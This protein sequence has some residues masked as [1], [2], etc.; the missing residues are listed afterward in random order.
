MLPYSVNSSRIYKSKSAKARQSNSLWI[1]GLVALLLTGVGGLWYLKS[2][3]AHVTGLLAVIT[4]HGMPLLLFKLHNVYLAK[5]RY[6]V[7]ACYIKMQRL[8]IG[9][10]LK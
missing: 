2:K 7:E 5:G 4:E 6:S 8:S 3:S 10:L 9:I 1:F